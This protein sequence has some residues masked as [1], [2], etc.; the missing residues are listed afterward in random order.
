[1]KKYFRKQEGF[2]LIEMIIALAIFTIVAVIAVGALLKIVDLNRKAFSLKTS[3]NNINFALESMSREM[4][5]GRDYN[6]MSGGTAT[7][8]V[9]LP[10]RLDNPL[11]NCPQS[12]NGTASW[13]IAFN[14][15]KS[16]VDVANQ[17][18]IYAY[19]YDPIKRILQKAQQNPNNCAGN[20]I[21]TATVSAGDATK[22]GFADLISGDVEITN[23]K[24]DLTIAGQPRVFF[25][26]KGYTGIRNKE[27]TTFGIQTTVSQRIK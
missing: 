14:T 8:F 24:V 18:V 21:T 15:S 17:N 27:R 9:T 20:Q 2:T 11:D 23:S 4:R 26:F 3:I 1:M 16:C 19:R 12:S 10:T 6:C 22:S 25:M 13:I 5:V 7:T